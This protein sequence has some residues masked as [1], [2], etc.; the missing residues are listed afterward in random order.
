[1][2]NIKESQKKNIN[3]T[4]GVPQ[5]LGAGNDTMT[6]DRCVACTATVA[7]WADVATRRHDKKEDRLGEWFL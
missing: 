7:K 5:P 3:S 2:A 4:R 6:E 1:V